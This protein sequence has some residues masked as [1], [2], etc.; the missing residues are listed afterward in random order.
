MDM[1]A[2]HH[3]QRLFFST[4]ARHGEGVEAIDGLGLRPALFARYRDL[5]RLRYDYPLVLIDRGP[6][7]GT[8]RSLSSIVD[9]VLQEIAPRG[10][11]GERLRKH[12][13]RLER[14]FRVLVAEGTRG[15]LTELWADAAPRL[16]T[17]GDPSAEGVLTHLAEK[18]QL[19]GE[20]VDCDRAMP[21]RVLAHMW[22]A[23]QQRKAKVFRAI[24]DRLVIKLSDILR[25]AYIHSQAGQGADAL[26]ASLGGAHRDAFDF[27]VMSRLVARNVPRDELPAS[28][29]RRIDGALAVLRAQRFHPDPKL[30]DRPD[31]PPAYAFRYDDCASAAAAY[32]E[33]LP[34]LAEVVKAIAIAEL[35]A[36]GWG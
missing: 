21:A 19:D 7:S 11:E 33:R 10:L 34:S 8:L 27:G 36:D 3:E 32:R 18:L 23:A 13:L 9:E 22:D 12:V 16:A 24:V 30:A 15:R 5:S 2:Q 14:E 25:A 28:R 26:R 35:E 29:R 31:A 1:A 17:P 6:G 4:G 20:V